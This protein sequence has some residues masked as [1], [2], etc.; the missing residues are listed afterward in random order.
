MRLIAGAILFTAAAAFVV[1]GI[2][3]VDL[4]VSEYR[5]P[6]RL[7]PVVYGMPRAEDQQRAERGEIFLAGCVA[8]PGDPTWLVV[9]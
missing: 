6:P 4:R 1:F 7:V 9:W 8:E 3:P 2:L 5:W